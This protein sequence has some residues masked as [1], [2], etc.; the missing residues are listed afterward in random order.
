MTSSEA[1]RRG[2]HAPAWMVFQVWAA[3]LLSVGIPSAGAPVST[4]IAAE[5][6]EAVEAAEAV[7]PP[8]AQAAPAEGAEAVGSVEEAAPPEDQ[9]AEATAPGD[10]AAG[11]VDTLNVPRT[12]V[13]SRHEMMVDGRRLS[14]EAGVTALPLVDAKGRRT[15]EIF[16]VDYRL[17]DAPAERRPV[18][19][20]FNGG[21]GAASAFLH[22]GALGPRILETLPD[23]GL[24]PPPARLADN[25]ATWLP[26][27]DLVFVDPVGTGYSRALAD[28]G[29]EE[30]RDDRFWGVRPDIET[31]GEV[32]RL[33]LARNERWRSP[34][35]IVGESYGGFRAALMARDLQESLG[36]SLNG[37]VLVS[38]VLEFSTIQEEEFALM[39]WAL[40]LP[41]LAASARVH[42]K[43]PIDGP[44][45][46]EVERFALGEYL[47]GLAAP[48]TDA[49][50][51]RVADLLGLPTDLVRR[52]RGRMPMGVFAKELLDAQGRVISLYDGSIV[53][54]DPNP[55]SRS[56]TVDPVLDAAI[57]PY[58]TAFNGYVR[59]E[60]NFRSDLPYRLLN[61]TVSRR[62]DWDGARGGPGGQDG[63]LDDLEA[64]LAVNPT[65]QVLIV[66]GLYDLVT[67]YF[68][69]RWLVDRMSVGDDIRA[70]V[71]LE[72]FDGGHMMYMRPD[73]RAQFADAAR[74]LYERGLR[75]DGVSSAPVMQ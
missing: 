49:F 37:L 24:A 51:D 73:V 13:R 32:I 42:G 28:G 39:P 25:P 17:E 20:V 40:K 70:N 33:W 19:F 58:T 59:D 27:T 30:A 61:R 72:T 47:V 11:S 52:Y 29:D 3:C 54:P 15:A 31:L 34:K 75:Q 64:A 67:P 43:G 5:P 7:G 10:V 65:M 8:P 38:P 44:S 41:S 16:I 68:A 21:P 71:T 50:A 18:T 4:A 60:L 53:G 35:F 56:V 6:P 2:R 36:I 69:S 55:R 74:R 1:G 45:P 46:A 23:G 57:G 22:L 63:A 66:H 26:F 14:Y 9:G 62:W 48:A 12:P